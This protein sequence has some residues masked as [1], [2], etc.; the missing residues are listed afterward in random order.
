LADEGALKEVRDR[1]QTRIDDALTF[2]EDSP[3]PA[4]TTSISTFSLK[5]NRSRTRVTL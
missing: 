3:E 1:I 2:A 5:I 4:P